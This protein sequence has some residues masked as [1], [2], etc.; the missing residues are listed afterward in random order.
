MF[1]C[2]QHLFKQNCKKGIMN[3]NQK[4]ILLVFFFFPSVR[5]GCISSNH[6]SSKCPYFISDFSPKVW[7]SPFRLNFP[8]HKSRHS[9]GSSA[10]TSFSIPKLVSLN[11]SWQPQSSKILYSICFVVSTIKFLSISGCLENEKKKKTWSWG[12]KPT[13]T[14]IASEALH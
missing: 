11:R 9:F 14:G 2:F 10:N 1:I 6:L 8:N 7:L 4:T 13:T 3:P 5:C 12:Q